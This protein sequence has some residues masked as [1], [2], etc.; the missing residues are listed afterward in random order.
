MQ[1]CRHHNCGYDIL[2][3]EGGFI[4][5]TLDGGRPATVQDELKDFISNLSISVVH[6][7]CCYTSGGL[8]M[9]RAKN[10]HQNRYG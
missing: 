1:V 5:K 8:V 3:L 10:E 6:A 4:H 9:N 7:S 2:L